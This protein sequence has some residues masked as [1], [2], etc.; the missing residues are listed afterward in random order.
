MWCC[1]LRCGAE[2]EGVTRAGALA[3]VHEHG[4]DRWGTGSL[5]L[6]GTVL[7]RVPYPVVR[8]PDG[9]APDRPPRSGRPPDVSWAAPEKCRCRKKNRRGFAE[10][11]GNRPGER[12]MIPH[13]F[14]GMPDRLRGVAKTSSKC[15]DRGGGSPYKPPHT[16]GHRGGRGAGRG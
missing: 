12:W 3:L 8:S 10:G 5:G 9:H 2:Y 14:K 6:R 1:M 15:V 7:R 13:D 11:P 4:L 16:D